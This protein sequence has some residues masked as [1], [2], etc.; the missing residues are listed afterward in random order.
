[1]CERLA[2]PWQNAAFRCTSQFVILFFLLFFSIVLY[3]PGATLVVPVISFNKRIA[4]FRDF[5][6]WKRIA[7][8]WLILPNLNEEYQF[9]KGL[10]IFYIAPI[11]ASIH[12]NCFFCFA[13]L[14]DCLSVSVSHLTPHLCEGWQHSTVNLYQKSCKTLYKPVD[15]L[16]I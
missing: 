7:F 10:V 1:M 3:S 15:S 12:F 2:Y 5:I 16:K 4:V 13:F 9:W 8:K 6:Y 11:G 14:F